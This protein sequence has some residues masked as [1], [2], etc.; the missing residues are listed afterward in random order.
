MALQ[1]WSPH[2]VKQLRQ[3]LGMTQQQFA[4][5]VGVA[6]GVVVSRWEVGD[7]KPDWRSRAAL[8]RLE[9]GARR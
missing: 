9:E 5:A 2:R 6:H 7:R 1:Q 3:R 8:E 4:E